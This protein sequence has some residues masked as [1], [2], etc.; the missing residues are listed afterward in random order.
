V[1]FNRK[2]LEVVTDTDE[3]VVSLAK[4]KRHIRGVPGGDDDQII[5]DF[6]WQATEVVKE[7]LQVGLRQQTLKLILDGFY[8]GED[9]YRWKS[10]G[11]GTHTGSIV[12]LLGGY[13]S[14]D[15]PY[16][17]LQ[18][19]TS[20]TTYDRDNTSSVFSSSLYSVDLQSGRLYL[21]E[22]E[23]WP[24][25]LRDYAAV[26]IEYIAGYGASNVP[27][28]IKGAILELVRASYDGCAMQISEHT[29]AMLSPY[30]RLDSLA[31]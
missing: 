31:W 2:S 4:A 10:L 19:V 16:P 7:Y 3:T 21:N 15:L 17:P 23:V 24:T 14:V 13:G 8:E 18:S 25:N 1:K 5:A 20:V 27:E 6:I 30:K 26:E 11:G 22:G 9:F 12:D 28:P 29:K